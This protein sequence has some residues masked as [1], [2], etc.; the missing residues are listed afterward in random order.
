MDSNLRTSR[1]LAGRDTGLRY[2]PKLFYSNFFQIAICHLRDSN[3]RTSRT[4]AGLVPKN[5]GKAIPA[6]KLSLT[7]CELVL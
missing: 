7:P 5:F 3:L 2:T 6:P 4:L 1:T